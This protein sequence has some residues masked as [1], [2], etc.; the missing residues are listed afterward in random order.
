MAK[1]EKLYTDGGQVSVGATAEVVTWTSPVRDW[2]ITNNGSKTVYVN[3]DGDGTDITANAL[4]YY[5]LAANET[6]TAS[7]F[8]TGLWIG[9]VAFICAA[10]ESSTVKYLVIGNY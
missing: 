3:L 8:G 6:I 1:N 10:A 4:L 9:S 7:I 2:T 5:P